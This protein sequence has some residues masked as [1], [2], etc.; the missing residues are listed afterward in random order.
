MSL[1][2]IENHNIRSN[3]GLLKDSNFP[4]EGVHKIMEK[5]EQLRIEMQKKRQEL[6][7]NE[8]VGP[9]LSVQM[10]ETTSRRTDVLFRLSDFSKTPNNA[11]L[12]Q[13]LKELDNVLKAYSTAISL[14]SIRI[15]I[16][17]YERDSLIDRLSSD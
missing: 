3:L 8:Y 7:A 17:Q 13:V 15:S 11:S 16:L 10:F 12:R 6:L 14:T 4:Q 9:K 1:A 5:L 2:Q